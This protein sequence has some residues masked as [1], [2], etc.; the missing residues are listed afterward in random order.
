VKESEQN[1]DHLLSSERGE[2]LNIT[3]HVFVCW[4]QKEQLVKLIF[5]RSIGTRRISEYVSTSRFYLLRAKS[6]AIIGEANLWEA[7][8]SGESLNITTSQKKSRDL[9]V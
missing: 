3:N 7:S 9:V 5:V 2:P 8:E 1:S 6:G 4:E